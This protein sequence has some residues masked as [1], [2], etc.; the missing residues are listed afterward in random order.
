M[1]LVAIEAPTVDIEAQ[2]GPLKRSAS[3]VKTSMRAI[4][5]RVHI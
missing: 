3:Y 4:V 2:A 1:M 5:G